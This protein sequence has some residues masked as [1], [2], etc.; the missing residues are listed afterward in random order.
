MPGVADDFY[1]EDFIDDGLLDMLIIVGLAG[2]LAILI[3]YRQQ[4][5]ME[6]RRRQERQQQQEQQGG[7][8]QAL[9]PQDRGVFPPA[10]DP[11]FN[12]WV[13]GG[14]GH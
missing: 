1:D 4:R 8:V 10:G 3:Y 2:A 5:Q 6:A 11:N 12:A 14:V 9:P 7:D 13:A